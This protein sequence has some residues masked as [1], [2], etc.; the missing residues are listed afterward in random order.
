MLERTASERLG[1]QI[2]VPHGDA[3]I[4]TTDVA[5]VAFR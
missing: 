4:D 3:R 5:R 1:Q 2:V